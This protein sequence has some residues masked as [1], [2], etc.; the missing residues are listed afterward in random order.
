[1]DHVLSYKTIFNDEDKGKQYDD[2]AFQ[3]DLVFR[4]AVGYGD[5]EVCAKA[6]IEFNIPKDASIIDF[7]CGTGLIGASIERQANY[8]PIIDG[9][10]ASQKM[11]DIAAEKKVYRKLEAK[12][13][14]TGE[15][16][17]DEYVQTYDHLVCSGSLVPGHIPSQGFD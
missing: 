7:G 11:L 17:P 1:M 15:K 6:V 5:P 2:R 12:Y 16:L 13:L 14:G 8:K 10:D 9:L 3:Y 4:D